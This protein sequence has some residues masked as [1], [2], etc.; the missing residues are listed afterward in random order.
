MDI[1]T[2]IAA[3]P[4]IIVLLWGI[5][6]PFCAFV[7]WLF[8]YLVDQHAPVPAGVLG[9][10]FL[11]IGVTLLA[12][13][14]ELTLHYLKFDALRRT[15]TGGP[16][17]V[18][19]RLEGIVDLP[20]LPT[21]AAAAWVAVELACVRVN[22]R[23]V[24][25]RPTATFETDCWSDRRQFPVHRRGRRR[26]AVIRFEIPDSP[27]PSD[28]AAAAAGAYQTDRSSRDR[29]IWEL[30]VEAAGSGPEFRRTLAVQVLP[31][32][33]GACHGGPQPG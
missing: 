9:G 15:L 4:R 1:H 21:S 13:T 7:G 22:C 20:T 31:S 23:S 2:I 29:Y 5:T 19:R 24:G 28:T 27:P 18:G 25:P 3:S 11:L 10:S 30:R 6:L 26:S 8:L 33:S 14:I 12:G 32:A 16:A 17:T